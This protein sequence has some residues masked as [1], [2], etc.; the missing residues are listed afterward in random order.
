MTISIPQLTIIAGVKVNG[1]F[2][3]L[4]ESGLLI[5]HV[6]QLPHDMGIHIPDIIGKDLIDAMSMLA[7]SGFRID[8]SI[9]TQN[10]PVYRQI[11]LWATY[12]Q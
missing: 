3:H 10:D 5:R 4:P 1:D 2:F 6:S 8:H 7:Y 12:T 11:I 9:V